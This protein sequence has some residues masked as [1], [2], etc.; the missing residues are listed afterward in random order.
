MNAERLGAEEGDGRD[1]LI[2]RVVRVEA[3]EQCDGEQR[4]EQRCRQRHQP[5]DEAI[6]ARHERQ[7]DGCKQRQ[8]E[9]QGQS[10]HPV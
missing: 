10:G 4:H 6:V 5:R 9:N 8:N 1:E 3:P 7:R 2:T